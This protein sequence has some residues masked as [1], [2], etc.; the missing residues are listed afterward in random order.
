MKA[1]YSDPFSFPLPEDHRFPIQ[2]YAL[3]RQRL[4]ESDL[5]LALDLSVPE[6]ASDDQLLLVHD[7]DY[8]QKLKTGGLSSKEARKIGLPWSM[9]LVERSR[10]S[11]GGTI[12]ASRWALREGIAINLAGGTH[13]A[14]RDH[15]AGYCVFNDVAVAGRAM[16]KEVGIERVVILDCDVHQGDGSASI[17]AGDASVFTFSIHAEKNYPFHKVAS[18]L[19]IALPDNTGDEAYLEALGQGVAVALLRARANLA[20]YLAGADPYEDDRL[21]RLALTKKGLMARDRLVLQACRARGLPVAIVMSGGYARRIEDTVEIHFNTVRLA[22]AIFR[23]PFNRIQ[24][25]ES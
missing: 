11:V 8:L 14:R 7:S 6:P 3:L 1:F 13:H 23:V 5:H 4:Q 15:G 2:K 25:S 10:R 21:G 22:S 24:Q 18:D 17:F 16:Q 12:A 19:D 20:I 9:E